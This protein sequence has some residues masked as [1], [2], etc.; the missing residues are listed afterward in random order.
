MPNPY[1]HPL[2]AAERQNLLD[3]VDELLTEL[4]RNA[5]PEAGLTL[6]HLAGVRTYLIDGMRQELGENLDLA[7]E[8]LI[9]LRDAHLKTGIRQFIQ[10]VRAREELDRPPGR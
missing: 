6:E 4:N 8:S 10:S 1:I 9:A 3:R 5:S 2:S 7:E